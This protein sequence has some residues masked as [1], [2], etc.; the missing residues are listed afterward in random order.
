MHSHVAHERHIMFQE[1][2]DNVERRLKEMLKHV[3]E[4]MGDKTDEVFTQMRRDYRSI[5]GGGDIPQDGQM[6][7]KDQRLARK[8]V[9]KVIQGVEKAFMKVAGLITDEEDDDKENNDP[10]SQSDDEDEGG[11]APST[12]EDARDPELKRE[13]SPSDQLSRDEAV[14]RLPVAKFER[15]VSE[16]DSMADTASDKLSDNND[17]SD[18]ASVASNVSD[19]ASSD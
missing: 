17:E 7:P 2:A 3:E 1:S 14:R 13:D 16:D 18:S 12:K 15:A 19:I 5:I 9:M 6:L 10:A 4:L 8:G 11:Q